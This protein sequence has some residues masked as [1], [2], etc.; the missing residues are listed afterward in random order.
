[1]S[2]RVVDRP[3]GRIRRATAP[4]SRAGATFQTLRVDGA[5]VPPPSGIERL[6]ANVAPLTHE[7]LSPADNWTLPDAES[8]REPP[9][10]SAIELFYDEIAEDFDQ[11]MNIYDLQRRVETIFDV[12]LRDCDLTGRTLLDAGCGTGWFSLRACQRGA[13]VTAL[14]IGPRLLQQ[15]RRK[16]DARTVCGDVL[17]LDFEDGAFDVVISSECIEH[18]RDSRQAVRELVR[19]CRPG[20]L[21]V[22]TTPNHFWYWLC[23]IANK[24]HLRPYEG[25]ENWPRWTELRRWVEEA[26][27]RTLEMRGIHLFPFQIAMFHPLLKFLDRFGRFHGR[28]CVNQAILATKP[29]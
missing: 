12:L 28:F 14:D 24:L 27:G 7:R 10:A 1:M 18:T 26:G 21:I 17:Q 6:I 15:V 19:V 23:A 9:A 2:E 22:I 3:G 5:A 25:L 13:K 20:G 4:S 11:I 16:C 8:R 29:C